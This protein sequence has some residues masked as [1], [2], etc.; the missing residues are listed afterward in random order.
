MLVTWYIG[1]GILVTSVSIHYRALIGRLYSRVCESITRRRAESSWE[2]IAWQDECSST[3]DILV[4]TA[5]S[6]SE[7]HEEVSGSWGGGV[8]PMELVHDILSGWWDVMPA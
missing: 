2:C 7:C 1:L 4:L 5:V 3:Y 6:G 8:M